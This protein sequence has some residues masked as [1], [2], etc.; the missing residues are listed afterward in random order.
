MIMRRKRRPEIGAREDLR[1]C[2]EFVIH[3]RGS[4]SSQASGSGAA[5]VLILLQVSD[6]DLIQSELEEKGRES[7]DA[8]HIV[9]S[10]AL[11]YVW[12]M[13]VKPHFRR[14]AKVEAGKYR[15]IQHCTTRPLADGTVYVTGRVRFDACDFVR[16]S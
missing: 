5:K 11:T 15:R 13:T 7:L 2:I 12:D 8:V 4:C 16:I 14:L 1:K 6:V 9:T 10:G 3:Q